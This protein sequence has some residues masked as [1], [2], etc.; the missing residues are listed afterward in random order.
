MCHRLAAH[1]SPIDQSLGGRL[2]RQRQLAWSGFS[3][4]V[5][6]IDLTE[7]IGRRK[8]NGRGEFLGRSS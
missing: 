3:F 7:T 4:L 2:N 5:E 8:Q 1:S 6:T